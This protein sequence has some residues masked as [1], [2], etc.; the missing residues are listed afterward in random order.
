MSVPNVPVCRLPT[1]RV[2]GCCGGGVKHEPAVPSRWWGSQ[3]LGACLSGI[4]LRHSSKSVAHNGA[5]FVRVS[6]SVPPSRQL[7]APTLP[8]SSG[9]RPC[10]PT[11]WTVAPFSSGTDRSCVLG[12]LCSDVVGRF[13]HW[14]AASGVYAYIA[15]TKCGALS[16]CYCLCWGKHIRA[17]LVPRLVLGATGAVVCASVCKRHLAQWHF[18]HAAAAIHMHGATTTGPRGASLMHLTLVDGNNRCWSGV[19]QQ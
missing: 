17:L 3:Q 10:R 19:R 16:K 11:V 8:H 13:L 12:N 6:L 1:A 15:F 5:C 7:P 14:C 9:M 18:L 4:T 2:G